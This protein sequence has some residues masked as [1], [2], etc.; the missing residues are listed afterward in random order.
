MVLL[1]QL[2]IAP[3][4]DRRLFAKTLEQIQSNRNSYLI[5]IEDLN[6]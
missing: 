3:K 6:T 2:T 5:V 4:V 1:E